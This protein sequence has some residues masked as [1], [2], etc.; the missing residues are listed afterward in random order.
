MC[1]RVNHDRE[2]DPIVKYVLALFVFCAIAGLMWLGFTRLW[3]WL[4]KRL[5]RPAGGREAAQFLWTYWGYGAERL[6]DLY[7]KKCRRFKAATMGGELVGGVWAPGA[8]TVAHEPGMLFADTALPTEM[9]HEVRY[10]RTGAIWGGPH[11]YDD[12]WHQECEAAREVLRRWE[13]AHGAEAV[14]S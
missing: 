11:N 5:Y 3:R 7:W 14:K 9:L 8:V 2:E 13:L 6:P 10:K 12:E 4:G 1:R